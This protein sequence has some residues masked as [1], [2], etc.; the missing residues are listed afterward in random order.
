MTASR[1]ALLALLLWA[2]QAFAVIEIAPLSNAELEARYRVLIEELRCP[3]CQNQ[4]LADSDAPIAA[5]LRGEVR[6]LLE[7]GRGDD[8]IAA[9]LVARYGE[10][11]LYRPA[12]KGNTLLLWY[13]PAAL[14]L[15]GLV[16]LALVVRRHRRDA[17]D[18][19]P[20]D[21]VEQQ[22]LNALLKGDDR[23][24]HP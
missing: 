2:C 10:F 20:L 21:P 22:R 9:H 1:L 12:V 15:L 24:P 3:K 18:S 19:A 8:E 7:E 4:N 13:G 11:V 23:E 17:P 14:A 5:D 16:A 6:R